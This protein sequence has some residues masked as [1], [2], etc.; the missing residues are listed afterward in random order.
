MEPLEGEIGATSAIE[1][2]NI[3]CKSDRSRNVSR[4]ATSTRDDWFTR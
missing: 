4:P 1:S 2:D 3:R